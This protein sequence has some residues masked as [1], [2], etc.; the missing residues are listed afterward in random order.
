MLSYLLLTCQPTLPHTIRFA[1]HEAVSE[2]VKNVVSSW[3]L[4]MVPTS[5]DEAAHTMTAVL[6]PSD[7]TPAQVCMCVCVCV[8]VC[9]CMC[10][11]VFAFVGS[12]F[13]HDSINKHCSVVWCGLTNMPAFS[14]VKTG[15]L[16]FWISINA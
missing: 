4:K 8:C 1:K 7:M 13:C 16:F 14:S 10:V 2:H 3:G 6:F 5:R 11:C 12:T 9:V 15:M